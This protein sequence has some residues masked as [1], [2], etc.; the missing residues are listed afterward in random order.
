MPK[1]SQISEYSDVCCERTWR[2]LSQLSYE[3]ISFENF[4]LGMFLCS[5][6]KFIEADMDIFDK[7]MLE[8]KDVWVA[9]V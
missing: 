4:M 5:S 7:L 8:Q 6:A 3:N 2:W 9:R 1:K